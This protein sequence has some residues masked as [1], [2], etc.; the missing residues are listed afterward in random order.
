MTYIIQQNPITIVFKTDPAQ[1][2]LNALKL[3]QKKESPTPTAVDG[4]R[5]I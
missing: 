2:L 1:N 4:G 3:Y 5:S